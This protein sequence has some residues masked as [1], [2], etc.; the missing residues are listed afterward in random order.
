MLAR[1]KKTR[2]YLDYLER[3]YNNVQKAWKL[4]NDKCA[5]DDFRF[6]HDDYVWHSIDGDVKHHDNSKLSAQEFVQ[7]RQHLYPTEE[8]KQFTGWDA[9]FKK[10][11]KHHLIKNS[12]HWE[13]LVQLDKHPYAD[14]YAVMIVVDWVAMGFEE[15][16]LDARDFYE[17]NKAKIKLPEW[18]IKLMYEIFDCIYP[19]EK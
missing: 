16:M 15:G 6:M 3:H 9:Q 5:N 18:A 8:E 13:T 11:W 2:E 4:I 1:I 7:Y 12:H 10:A 17:K 14:M 19:L